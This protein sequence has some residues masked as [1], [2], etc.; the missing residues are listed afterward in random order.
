VAGFIGAVLIV[1]NLLDIPQLPQKQL[2]GLLLGAGLIV[3]MGAIDDRH[4]IPARIK[5]VGQ[6]IAAAILPL[7]G[8]GITVISNP[9]GSNWII[10]PQWLAFTLTIIWVVAV[11]NAINLIDGLDGL[12][13]G[14]AAISCLAFA[15]IAV[16]RDQN[17]IALL[18]IA[19]AG[20]TLGFLPWNFNPA[21]VFMGDVGAYFIGFIIG[22]I[23][24]ISAFKVAASLSIFVPLLVLAIPLLETI[25]SPVRRCIKGQSAFTADREHIHHKLLEQGLSQR[26]VVL[27]MYSVTALCCFIA[28]WI[29]HPK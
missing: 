7:F 28:V 26:A 24:V 15:I 25:M 18:A 12:A 21:K 16:M 3:I 17:A 1:G 11:T 23:T 29:S 27:V 22:G 4:H 20:G 19:L 9:F 13:A 6:I 2:T 10:P 14:V 5:L 8:A